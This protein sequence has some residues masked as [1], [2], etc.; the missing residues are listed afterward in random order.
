MSN[1]NNPY[2]APSS[3]VNTGV[4]NRSSIPKVIGIISIILALFGLLASISNIATSQIIPE[5]MKLQIA[6]GFDKV[7]LLVMGFIN[8]ITALW[9]LYI[10]IKLIKYK[11]K[12][13]R[14]YN[15]Y[16]IVSIVISIAT[17]FYLQSTGIDKLF[18][19][20][21]SMLNTLMTSS[22]I[23][24]L[25]VFSGPLFMTIVALLLNQQNVKKSLS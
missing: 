24:S 2:A 12:G 1:E 21:F 17:F 7:Y 25:S 15:Y 20:E 8:I 13:R 16:L 11:D 19:R 22:V 14:H 23:A 10:G 4:Q 5:V 18:D 3:N 9:A 6:M